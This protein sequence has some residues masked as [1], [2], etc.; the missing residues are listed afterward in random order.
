MSEKDFYELLIEMISRDVHPQKN[1]ILRLLENAKLSCDKTMEYTRNKWDHYKEYIYITVQPADVVQLIEFK[2]YIEKVIKQIYPVNDDYEYEFF[3]LEI[4][5]GK[6][7]PN[8]LVS[9]NVHFEN[10]QNKII[11]EIRK[12]DYLIWIAMAWFTNVDI[13]NELV[14]KKQAGVNIQI[15]IDDNDKNRTAPFILE[16]EFE[17]YRVSIWSSYKNLMHDKFCIIDLKTVVHGTFNWTNSANYNKETISIDNNSATAKKFADE[18]I[19]LKLFAM[20]KN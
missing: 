7:V 3:G 5:P 8:E 1:K 16:K 4:K 12:A 15:V 9:Q 10:I 14:K 18:F 19:K 17:T 13:Y 6:V 20:S 2:S 11:S